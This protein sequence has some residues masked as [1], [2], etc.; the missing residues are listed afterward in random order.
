MLPVQPG[1]LCVRLKVEAHYAVT[2]FEAINIACTDHRTAI[3][4][5]N[6]H[7]CPHDAYASYLALTTSAIV[8]PPCLTFARVRSQKGKMNDIF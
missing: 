7:T 3:V 1:S 8:I 2:L 4:T 5:R 6:L